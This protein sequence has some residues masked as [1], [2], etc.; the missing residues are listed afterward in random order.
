ME[1]ASGQ[2]SAELK[3]VYV[4]D[5]WLQRVEYS[6]LNDRLETATS[7]RFRSASRTS[8]SL[9]IFNGDESSGWIR[10]TNWGQL[11]FGG[12]ML[13]AIA[14]YT[15]WRTGAPSPEAWGLS[16][17]SWLGLLCI[18]FGAVLFFRRRRWV[19]FHTKSGQFFMVWENTKDCHGFDE[20]V[21]A[22]RSRIT[23]VNHPS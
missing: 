19:A 12:V 18:L 13:L 11:L 9:L 3:A 20:F 2:S 15:R 14:G 7:L 10:G 22:I 23:A 21:G 17:I 16:A 4:G 1:N 6:L 8:D 5:S